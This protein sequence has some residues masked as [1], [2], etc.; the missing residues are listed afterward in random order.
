MAWVDGASATRSRP[1][2]LEVGFPDAREGAGL[3]GASVAHKDGDTVAVGGEV[4]DGFVL[5]AA[6]E[7]HLRAGRFAE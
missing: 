7:I 2:A 4:N 6:Q 5:F 3:A 1:L